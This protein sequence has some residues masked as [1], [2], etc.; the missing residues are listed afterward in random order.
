M[1]AGAALSGGFAGSTVI[2]VH[3]GSAVDRA[4]ATMADAASIPT[5]EPGAASAPGHHDGTM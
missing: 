5:D 1:S 2:G 4:S 3:A